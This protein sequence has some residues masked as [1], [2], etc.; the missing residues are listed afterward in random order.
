MSA[1]VTFNY[2]ILDR[3]KIDQL[4]ELVEPID[5]QYEAEVIVG[6]PV[7][8]IEGSTLPNMLIYKFKNFAAANQWF[9]SEEHQEVSISETL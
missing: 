1:Y 3:R 4:T 5:E 2:K 8:N 6:S 7:K 9:Y